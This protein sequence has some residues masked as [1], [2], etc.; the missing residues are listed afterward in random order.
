MS[1]AQAVETSQV[2]SDAPD[3]NEVE[4]NEYEDDNEVA[5]LYGDDDQSEQDQETEQPVDDSSEEIEFNQKQYKLPK[6][7]AVAVKDMQ[8][9]Y[10]VKTQA[11][12]EQRKQFEAQVQFHQQNI[13]DVAQIQALNNQLSEFGKVDWN[14]L[15]AE[16]PVKAQQL[17]FYQKQIEDQ[18]NALAQTIQQK[19]QQSTLER[20]QELAKRIEESESVLRRDIKEWSPELETKIVNFVGS[21]YSIS[22]AEVQEIKH[23][24]NAMKLLYDAYIGKQIIQK[25]T[26]KPKIAQAKPVTTLTAKGTKVSKDPTEM[27]DKEFDQWR[28]GQIKKR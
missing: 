16:D 11:V 4:Q 2:E 20:Q 25:Q 19:N 23:N 12:A 24:P 17:F 5:T 1:E 28:R 22:P 18:R 3:L 7:I 6:D 8:K 27:S 21:V 13:Q 9:D 14:A 15:S 10:T 26:A